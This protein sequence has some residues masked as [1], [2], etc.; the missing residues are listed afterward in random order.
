MSQDESPVKNA[1][2][3]AIENYDRTIEVILLMFVKKNEKYF[4]W[5]VYWKFYSRV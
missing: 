4:L 5:F 3:S 1:L 2:S